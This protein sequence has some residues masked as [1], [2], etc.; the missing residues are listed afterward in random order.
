MSVVTVKDIV[1]LLN[2]PQKMAILKVTKYRLLFRSCV[3]QRPGTVMVIELYLRFEGCGF[4]CGLFSFQ[5]TT[6]V[7]YSQTCASVTMQYSL[8]WNCFSFLFCI[9]RHMQKFLVARSQPGCLMKV[10]LPLNWLYILSEGRKEVV[11]VSYSEYTFCKDQ[12]VTFSC[13]T[14]TMCVAPLYSVFHKLNGFYILS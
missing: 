9:L 10:V 12:F 6:F 11:S 7:G 8:V 1:S 13:D 2:R 14:E 5:L 3:H 4:Q